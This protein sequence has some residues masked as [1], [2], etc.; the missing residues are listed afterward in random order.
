VLTNSLAS[1][2][3]PVVHAGYARLR[4]RLLAAGVE[5]YE[6]RPTGSLATARNWQVGASSGASLHTKAILIDRRQVIVGSM[7][8]DPRSR[9]Y[10]TEI[11]LLLE[12]PQLGARLGSLF[13]Q[14]VQPAHAFN[15]KLA[16]IGPDQM[17]LVWITEEDGKPARYDHEPAG[18]W[19]RFLSQ[20]LGALAPEDLL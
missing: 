3:V 19:R 2:D 13:E 17:E 16:G 7:N 15:V 6:M 5:L 18:L 12:S 10:N 14:A 9:L 20:L 11:A 1:T 8:L 4:Y